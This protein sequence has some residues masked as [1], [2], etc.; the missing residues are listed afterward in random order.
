MNFMPNA[1][2]PWLL[3]CGCGVCEF[4]KQLLYLHLKQ[5]GPQQRKATGECVKSVM[6][7]KS[8][9]ILFMF[10]LCSY[11]WFMIMLVCLF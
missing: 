9:A 7:V 1:Q 3:H 6:A 10:K 11:V 4:C 2:N 8:K 5:M